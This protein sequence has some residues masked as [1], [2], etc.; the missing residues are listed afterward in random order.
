MRAKTLFATH[1]HELT[2]L[3]AQLDAVANYNVRVSDVRGEIVFTHT[4][5][6]GGAD[7]SYGLQVA[8]LAGIP[9]LVIQ[10]AQ[11]IL[12]VLEQAGGALQRRC[13]PWCARCQ[14]LG[15]TARCSRKLPR[16]IWVQCRH[17]R[18]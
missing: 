5:A 17:C 11:E 15:K 14:C 10:R 2:Q 9:R 12:A 8:Q 13:Q 4:I 3:A 6:A 18:R 16:L 7:R 1:Y